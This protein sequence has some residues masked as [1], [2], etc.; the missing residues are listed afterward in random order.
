V[1]VRCEQWFEAISALADGEDPGVDEHLLEAHLAGCATCQSRREQFDRLRRVARIESARPMPDLSGRIVK[2]TA[3]ADRA[4][5]WVGVRVLLVAVALYIIAMSLR[6]LFTA[7][8]S[9]DA[10]HAT[11]H[12]GSFTLAYGVALLVVVV[13]PARARTVLPVGITVA[14]ALVITAGVDIFE[15]RVPLAGETLHL[16]EVASVVLLWLLAVPAL[17]RQERTGRGHGHA[18]ASLWL[19]GQDEDGRES[20]TGA[21]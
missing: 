18:P 21:G 6:D 19:V 14:V 11:R 20:S 5:R 15:G 3:L 7:D 10:V 13:R 16:P 1:A 12:L 9:G 17:H 2:A 4:G 8:S